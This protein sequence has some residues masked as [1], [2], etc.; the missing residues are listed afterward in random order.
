MTTYTIQVPGLHAGQ[1]AIYDHP[2]RYKIV[3]CGRRF[4]KTQLGVYVAVMSM[5]RGREVGWFAPQSDYYDEAWTRLSRVLKPLIKNKDKNRG[6]MEIIGEQGVGG[7]ILRMFSTHLDKDSGRS[8]AF[9]DLIYDEAGLEPMLDSMWEN[10]YSYC[11]IDRMGKAWI[12]GTSKVA[13]IGFRKLFRRGER[14]DMD[15]TWASF[16]AKSFD[17]PFLPEEAKKEQEYKRTTMSP[18]AWAAEYEGG[19]DDGSAMFFPSDLLERLASEC[20][21]PRARYNIDI[22]LPYAYDRDHAI[23]TR[24]VGK[25]IVRA[26]E[27][28][29]WSLWTHLEPDRKGLLRPPQRRPWCIGVDIGTGV[30]ANPTVFSVGDAETGRKLAVY[31]ATR[32]T[33]VEAAKLA[34]IA[35]MWFGGTMGQALINFEANGPGEAFGQE[36]VRLAYAGIM[37]RTKGGARAWEDRSEVAYG[38]WSTPSAK[39]QLLISYREAL[40]GETFFNPSAEGLREC[41]PYRYDEFGRVVTDQAHD[42]TH[43][44]EVIADALLLAAFGECPRVEAVEVPP[45]VGSEAWHDRVQEAQEDDEHGSG[46]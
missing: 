19:D 6:Y 17:N 40:T 35:G 31:R 34:A 14:R 45:P 2:A 39:E 44:D 37:R 9:D 29:A 41:L 26:D 28:G 20:Q 7:G 1:K 25:I 24:D 32:V 3:R 15:G 38:W 5:L 43:G 8:F 33:P 12:L 13:G 36:L 11:M 27:A 16:R 22:Q 4:G 30:G 23:S 46:W 10:V 42:R 21:P 18:V